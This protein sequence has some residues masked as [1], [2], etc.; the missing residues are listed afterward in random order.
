ME[1]W[2]RILRKLLLPVPAVLFIGVPMSA[3]LLFYTFAFA[4]E[5]EPIAYAAYVISAYTMTVLC[6]RIPK[7]FKGVSALLH[8][9]RTAH[10]FLTDVSFRM[11]ASLYLSL[12]INLLYAIIKF[13]SGIYYHS[14]WFQ[15]FGIY[16]TFLA[17]MRFL[18]L[19]HVKRN[20]FGKELVSE[21]KRYRLCGMILLPMSL[22]LSGVVVLAIERNEGFQYAGYL[23]YVV[24]MYAFYA[25]IS[26]VT[27][28]IRYRKYQSPV[29]SAAKAISLVSAL[30]SLFS[31]ETAMLS[32]FGDGSDPAFRR[33]MIATTSAGVCVIVLSMAVYM[34][35]YAAKQINRL[36][37][38]IT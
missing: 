22:V 3:A 6:V 24:A 30:V 27:N 35:V 8:R 29:M 1:K 32:Q 14:I 17:A 28:L 18:L 33:I 10:R 16:Y 38:N 15:A 20:A 9:N 7:L 4:C 26:A 21:W 5:D 25:V 36:Q 31:L 12:G 11:H 37:A 19:R 34:T 2:K 13:L 23:I